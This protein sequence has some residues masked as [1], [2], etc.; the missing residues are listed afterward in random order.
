MQF[1]QL[2]QVTSQLPQFHAT[3]MFITT[4]YDM[5]LIQKITWQPPGTE[6]EGVT[7]FLQRTCTVYHAFCGIKNLLFGLGFSHVL[8][9]TPQRNTPPPNGEL[10]C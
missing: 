5:A 2:F 9:N 1:D 7:F 6:N 3:S 10:T 8:L 4:S